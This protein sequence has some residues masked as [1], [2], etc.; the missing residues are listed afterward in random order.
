MYPS[1]GS[2]IRG[3]LNTFVE[4]GMAT[5]KFFIGPMVF[6]PFE[7][8]L[9]SGQYP[10]LKKG[11]GS[12]MKAGS[13]LRAP[14]GSYGEIDRSWDSDTYDTIDRGLEELIDDTQQRDL[15]RFFN[16]E[17]VTSNLVRRCVQ[18]DHEV[19]VAAALFNTTNFGSATNSTVAY[20]A[21]NI[22]TMNA[23][24]DI[25][26]AIEKVNDNGEE[27]NT[28][29]LSPNVFNRVKLS[30]LMQNFIRGNRPSD[31]TVNITP[32]A[33]A[34][35]F[36]ENGITQV[37]VGRARYDSAKKGQAFSSARVWSDTYIW[38]GSVAEGDFMNGGAGRTIVWNEEG[39]LFV[40]EAYRD[41]KRRSGVIRVRQNTAEKVV[42]DGCGTL[43]ATQYS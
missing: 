41:E 3:D 35:A 27:A 6:P 1:S 5:D 39:G 30:T 14:K 31:S 24:A 11:N 13:T 20:T 16:Q 33:V 23:P 21:A 18:L 4:E 8:D 37:L 42:N 19:R 7:V 22:A 2:T 9:R 38:V 43:I 36:A 28:I 29:V 26:A 12:L 32:G 25:L 17:V 15:K 10:R 40:T 34:Q